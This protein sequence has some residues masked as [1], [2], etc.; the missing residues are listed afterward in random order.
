MSQT[1]INIKSLY[2]T[3]LT[4]MTAENLGFVDLML[5][6]LPTIILEDKIHLIFTAFKCQLT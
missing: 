5:K 4:C 3:P 6:L 2:Q 1:T